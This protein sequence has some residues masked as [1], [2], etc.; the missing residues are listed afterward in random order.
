MKKLL[1]LIGIIV[2]HSIMYAQNS[3]ILEN[4]SPAQNIWYTWQP[5]VFNTSTIDPSNQNETVGYLLPSSNEE[6]GSVTARIIDTLGLQN[7]LELGSQTL[8]FRMR[9]DNPH[10]IA[11]TIRIRLYAEPDP[12]QPN[13]WGNHMYVDVT[14]TV[15]EEWATYSVDLSAQY[16]SNL[17]YNKISIEPSPGIAWNESVYVDDIRFT[18]PD[19]TFEIVRAYSSEDG[20]KICAKFNSSFDI[21]TDFTELQFRNNG[22]L[23]S[24]E[25]FEINLD[26]TN[27]LIAHMTEPIT[28][29]DQLQLSYTNGTLRSGLLLPLQNFDITIANLVNISTIS[30]WRDDFNS[31]SDAITNNISILP[32]ASTT[33]GEVATGDGYYSVL[34]NGAT[35]WYPLLITIISDVPEESK[36]VIDLSGQEFIKLRYRI[37]PNAV[38]QTCSLRVDLKDKTNDRMSDNMMFIPLQLSSEWTEIVIDLQDCLENLYGSSPG[39]VDQG[40][41]YQVALY[42]AEN[43]GDAA[44][45]YVPTLFNGTIEFDYIELGGEVPAPIIENITES[46]LYGGSSYTLAVTDS[47]NG[48]LITWYS[49][50]ELTNIVGYGNS[51]T[52]Q[53]ILKGDN[54]RY[55]TRTNG[56]KTSIISTITVDYGCI[57]EVFFPTPDQIETIYVPYYKKQFTLHALSNEYQWTVNGQPGGDGEIFTK[58][59]DKADTIYNISAGIPYSN[60]LF[61]CENMA[62]KSELYWKVIITNELPFVN[63]I[64]TTIYL[65][66]GEEKDLVFKNNNQYM[67][68]TWNSSNTESQAIDTVA[69]DYFPY[70]YD[71]DQESEYTIVTIK[72]IQDGTDTLEWQRKTNCI[73]DGTVKRF[74]VVVGNGTIDTC[75]KIEFSKFDYAICEPDTTLLN[76]SLQYVITE[77]V[78]EVYAVD[79][80]YPRGQ[81]LSIGKQ[82]ARMYVVFNNGCSVHVEDSIT[83]TQN[84]K[85]T[86]PLVENYMFDVQEEKRIVAQLPAHCIGQWETPNNEVQYYQGNTKQVLWLQ[87]EHSIGEYTH[88]VL[89]LDTI[90]NCVSNKAIS[91]VK[92]VSE[93]MP[94]IYGTVELDNSAFT[95]GGTVQL[96]EKSGSNYIPAFQTDI[97]SDGTFECKYLTAGTYILRAI[98][99]AEFSVT[100]P[101]VLPTYYYSTIDW[102]DAY[103]L[104]LLGKV[105]ELT[106]LL[107]KYSQPTSG[108]GYIAGSVS[109]EDNLQGYNDLFK[110]Y[111]ILQ[112]PVYAVQNGVI[113]GYALTDVDGN[114]TISN[115]AKGS[116]DIYID[117][118]GY[119][120]TKERVY[121]PESGSAQVNFIVKNGEIALDLDNNISSN[122]IAVYPNPTA[123]NISIAGEYY[124]AHVLL[125]DAAGNKVLSTTMLE[126]IDVS[127]LPQGV[128]TIQIIHTGGI[129]T[130]LF[131]KE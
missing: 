43:Q 44:S 74:V 24:I 50:A 114:F 131:I 34:F 30:G 92:V 65:E 20:T 129:Q 106:I 89:A 14:P 22:T 23:I 28:S 57:E 104:Q 52:T 120:Y 125:F 58:T 67:C 36:N 48:G 130:H 94:S 117:I 33:H 15:Y 10:A 87:I 64:D 126:N 59:I 76:Q 13:Y 54:I 108:N 124:S 128:Y 32:A 66:V 69:I 80:I 107:Q 99:N 17:L 2:F 95:L 18:Q 8:R 16:S 118:P 121:L 75:P 5:N 73:A 63:T 111:T 83:I 6:Y 81:V 91:N 90:T 86:T 35:G 55:A 97:N 4:F 47:I 7:T 31:D 1:L 29:S 101:I 3:F 96:Y 27:I 38:S 122:T 112:V 41:I 100:S 68:N 98:P 77:A 70:E 82:N 46:E 40:T 12:A 109:F 78:P 116:Y 84:A 88:A 25:S 113:V 21:E 19:P 115:L 53:L 49:D 72:G 103:E 119:S 51:L 71:I 123:N 93:S 62:V 26:N 127:Q 45:A 105:Q 9:V 85:P 37:A 102:S 42:F 11:K 110:E 61:I 56:D 60:S 79:T 39:K